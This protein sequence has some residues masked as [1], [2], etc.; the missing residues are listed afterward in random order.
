MKI[1]KP[2]TVRDMLYAMDF[3]GG[4]CIFWDC[5]ND[6]AAT[7]PEPIWKGHSIDIPYWVAEAKLDYSDDCEPVY[8]CRDLGEKYDHKSGFAFSVVLD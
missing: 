7:D 5:T 1:N 3:S 2:K 4:T 6:T 8:Y